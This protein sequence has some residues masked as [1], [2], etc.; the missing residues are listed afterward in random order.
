MA[1]RLEYYYQIDNL[2]TDEYK[3]YRQYK[4]AKQHLASKSETCLIEARN[5]SLRDC[6]A[7][8]NRRSKR[9]SKNFLMMELSVYLWAF[10]KNF[11]YVVNCF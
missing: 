9:Y 2:C 7:R 6:V 8:F 5:S 1:M 3:V 4:I 10:Y 11:G